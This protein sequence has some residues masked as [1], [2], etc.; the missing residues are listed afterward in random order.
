[1]SIHEMFIPFLFSDKK[2]VRSRTVVENAG[3]RTDI[4]CQVFSEL[5]ILCFL[6]RNGLTTAWTLERKLL[7]T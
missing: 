1:M 4:V 5:T 7:D 2:L 3:V 6:R